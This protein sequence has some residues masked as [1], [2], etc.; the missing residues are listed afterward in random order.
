[1]APFEKFVFARAGLGYG[2]IRRVA[3]Y[4]RVW[5]SLAGGAKEAY[6][7]RMRGWRMNLAFVMVTTAADR[8]AYMLLGPIVACVLYIAG[9]AFLI[10][11][12][13]KG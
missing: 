9:L 2:Q 1:M 4:V 3:R 8:P 7:P 13:L 5:R 6:R 12:F 11:G 10:H